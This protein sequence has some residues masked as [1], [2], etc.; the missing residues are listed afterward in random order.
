MFDSAGHVF[1]SVGERN[2]RTPAQDT[3]NHMGTIVRLH[4]D[5]RVPQDNP[6]VGKPGA[7]PEIWSYG[8]RNPQGMT[9]HPTTGQLWATEHGARGGDEINRPQAGRNYGWPAITHGVN[10]NG[11]P[12]TPDTARAGMEQP[13]LHWTPSIA[14]SG[15]AIYHGDRFPRWR[16][17]LFAGALAGQQLRRVVFDGD[18]PTHQETLLQGRGRVREVAVGPDG[19]LYLLFDGN[20]G[21]VARLEPA[22]G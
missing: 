21:S 7:K 9:L 22:G 1:I 18:R 17:H 12:I 3:T 4:D 14:P 15:L 10:Y 16:G 5:G 2:E 8:H 11:Q 19:Y 13:L 6:F 20:D